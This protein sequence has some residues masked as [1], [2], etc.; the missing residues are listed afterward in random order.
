MKKIF[1]ECLKSTKELVPFK[2]GQKVDFVELLATKCNRKGIA[3]QEAKILIKEKHN[4][5]DEKVTELIEKSY[6]N[7]EEYGK[8]KKKSLENYLTSKYNFRYNEVT[9]RIEYKLKSAKLYDVLKDFELNSLYRE[10]NNNGYRVGIDR[11]SKLLMSDF[12]Q[13]YNPFKEYFCNLPKWDGKDYISELASMVKTDDD[14]FW[15]EALKKW[16]VG[17]VATAL[18]DEL[19]NH[20][21]I[22][23]SG[24][25]GIG[26]STFID[27]ILPPELKKYKYSGLINPNNKDSLQLMTETIIIDLDELASL[28]RKEDKSLKEIITKL[29]IKLRRPYGR[30]TEDLPRRAS[31]MGSINDEQFLSDIT[32]NRRFLCF[33]I[34]EIEKEK[35]INYKGLYA[36][37]MALYNSNYKFWFDG[38]EIEFLNKRNEKFRV[39]TNVEEIILGKFIQST[40]DEATYFMTATEILND[41]REDFGLQMNN[42]NAI[43]IGK[44]MNA[45]S[46]IKVKKDGVY[47]YALRKPKIEI[48][49]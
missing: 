29:H 11:L 41:I 7:L 6:A 25:Q 27:K 3:V 32:G 47:K 9:G 1:N 37:I 44:I 13:V 42:T 26:K 45:Y 49:F 46:F 24:K 17:M 15:N 34:E 21:V 36:Q 43:Q 16:L 35:E 31:F 12:V 40:V 4:F 28:S 22:V 33:L 5:D 8:D 19:I 18:K 2:N 38:D 30:V 10:L 14:K 39:K 20:T 23:L 48:P